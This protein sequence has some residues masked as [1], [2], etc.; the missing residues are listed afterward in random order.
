M[1]RAW[2]QLGA[3]AYILKCR[4][5]SGCQG[6]QHER[7][8]EFLI[9]GFLLVSIVREELSFHLEGAVEK[10]GSVFGGPVDEQVNLVPLVALVQKL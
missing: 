8:D 7:V 2:T 6:V 4:F 5:Y 10:H 9:A 3:Q 1:L